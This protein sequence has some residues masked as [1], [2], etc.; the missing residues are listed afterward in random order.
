MLKE[1]LDGLNQ[2]TKLKPKFLT[3]WR[4][5]TR[6]R[7][8]G[9]INGLLATGDLENEMK[10]DGIFWTLLMKAPPAFKRKPAKIQ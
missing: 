7:G 2:R 5:H 3:V 9:E 1:I 4:G 6:R 10:I 8:V